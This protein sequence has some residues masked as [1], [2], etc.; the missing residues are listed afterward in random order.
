MSL[1]FEICVD[2]I[3]DY[4]QLEIL[5]EYINNVCLSGWLWQ[6]HGTVV[7]PNFTESMPAYERITHDPISAGSNSK[8]TRRF[9][10]SIPAIHSL[11]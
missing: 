8:Q 9:I 3:G 2:M 11:T 10:L 1:F 4:F 5:F 7:T 6:L